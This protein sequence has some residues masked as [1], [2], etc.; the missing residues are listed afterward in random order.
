MATT[1]DDS[2]DADDQNCLSVPYSTHHLT[3]I[4]NSSGHGGLIDVRIFSE[5]LKDTHRKDN[6]VYGSDVLNNL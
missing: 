3:I 5:F 4:V 6:I 1:I 2:D